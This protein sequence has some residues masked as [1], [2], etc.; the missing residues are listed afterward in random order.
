MSEHTNLLDVAG[1]KPDDDDRKASESKSNETRVS[2]QIERKPKKGGNSNQTEPKASSAG[3]SNYSRI[4]P[5]KRNESYDSKSDNQAF[6]EKQQDQDQGS[7]D[8]FENQMDG[9]Q[10]IKTNAHSG[11]NSQTKAIPTNPDEDDESDVREG[12]DNKV[13]G[14]DNKVQ[15][16]RNESDA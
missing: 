2:R 7:I 13:Q 14:S 9:M 1:L 6:D 4:I 5:M 10:G 16:S 8:W 11:A 3:S 15:D 12:S